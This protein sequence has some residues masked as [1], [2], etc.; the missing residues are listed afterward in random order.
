MRDGIFKNLPLP[1]A[2]RS[3]MRACGRAA[4]RGE[5]A[6]RFA[7]RA[8][9]RDANQELAPSLPQRLDR[10][11]GS[12]QGTLPGF[13]TPLDA[14]LDKAGAHGSPFEQSIFSQMRRLEREGVR[15]GAMKEQAV[16]GAVRD[17]IDRRMRQIEQH[18]LINGGAEALPIINAA[19]T[20]LG[21]VAR[22]FAERLLSGGPS[23]ASSA[24]RPLDLDEDLTKPK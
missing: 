5:T 3:L 18:G 20:A 4:E 7:Q 9:E 19:R 21:S 14:T 12:A 16:E 15:G 17:R 13:E 2:W 8:L 6:Q 11:A 23:T 22:P 1:G 10:L 24:R